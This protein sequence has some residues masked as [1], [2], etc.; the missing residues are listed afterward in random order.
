MLYRG[1][2]HAATRW[3]T[4]FEHKLCHSFL[5]VACFHSLQQIMEFVRQAGLSCQS[6]S[7]YPMR[8]AIFIENTVHGLMNEKDPACSLGF[9]H[10]AAFQI[11]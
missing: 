4:D 10:L 3:V 1:I 2:M 9:C 5:S 11:G 7:H 6:V 8:Q